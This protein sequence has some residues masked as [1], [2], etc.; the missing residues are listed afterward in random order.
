MLMHDWVTYD[1]SWLK[2]S[3]LYFDPTGKFRTIPSPVWSRKGCLPCSRTCKSGSIEMD[4]FVSFGGNVLVRTFAIHFWN[5]M[6]QKT[7]LHVTHLYEELKKILFAFMGPT[8]LNIFLTSMGFLS[9]SS[10]TQRHEQQR[11]GRAGSW[12]PSSKCTNPVRKH[13]LFSFIT[14]LVLCLHWSA[15]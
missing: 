4:D 11:L 6:C 3:Q 2:L 9:E 14:L 1:T 15:C 13:L 10:L 12:Q 8:C 7:L 5:P